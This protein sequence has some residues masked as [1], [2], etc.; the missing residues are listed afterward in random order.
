MVDILYGSAFEIALQIKAKKVS[1]REIVSFYLDRIEK[2]NSEL[3]AVVQLDIERA[4]ARAD[5]ADAAALAGESWGSLHGLPLTIKDAYLT[6][7]IVTANGIPAL[8]GNVPNRNADVVQKYID[9]GAI[10]LGKTNTP[11]ASGDYQSFNDIYGT[12][13][14]PW[15]LNLTCGGSS[16]GAGAALAA[17]MTP[18]EL[19]GD[20]GG[21]IRIPSHLNG[22]YGHKPSHGIVSQR[23]LVDWPDQIA[24]QDL[25]VVGPMAVCAQDL[26]KALQLLVG[27]VPEKVLAWRVELPPPRTKDIRQLRVATYFENPDYPIDHEVKDQ[28]ESVAVSLENAGAQ[29]SREV[30]PDIDF[31]ENLNVYLKIMY[32]HMDENV[33]E[34]VRKMMAQALD[35]LPRSEEIVAMFGGTVA[36]WNRVNERRLQLQKKWTEFFES[37]DVLLAPILP[38]PAFKHDHSP[39]LVRRWNVNGEDRSAMIDTLFWAAFSLLTYLPATAVPA[40]RTQSQNL[41][42]G[43][44]IVGPYLED[45]TPLEVAIMLEECHQSFEPPSAYA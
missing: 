27:P 37:Y 4:L 10:I 17:G 43:V 34:E 24:E 36:N 31:Q 32:S 21:S 18:L 22:V 13:N 1:S 14:N 16:G 19:G 28:L 11:L 3:N 5:A 40:G 2:F 30:G 26:R 41:P 29:V 6:E 8:E 35:Y 7:G 9:A 44:Q 12:T 39:I 23:S 45:Q 15:D 20:I 25:W 38:L 33:P 42:V